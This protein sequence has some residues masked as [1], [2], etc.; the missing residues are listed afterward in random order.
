MPYN[1]FNFVEDTVKKQILRPLKI[2]IY[3]YIYIYIHGFPESTI[4]LDLDF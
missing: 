4:E 1:C 3:I 2:H